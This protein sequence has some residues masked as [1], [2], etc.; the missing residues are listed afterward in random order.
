[1]R[2][3]F[4][5]AMGGGGYRHGIS[6]HGISKHGNVMNRAMRWRAAPISPQTRT[7]EP[8]DPDLDPDP[9]FRLHIQ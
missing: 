4:G 7:K 5:Q 8:P 2:L 6:R 3:T 9:D 1:M